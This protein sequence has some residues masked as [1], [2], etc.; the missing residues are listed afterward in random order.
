[1]MNYSMAPKYP[2]QDCSKRH[3]GCHS[4]CASYHQVRDEH[5]RTK[6]LVRA[7]TDRIAF[8]CDEHKRLAAYCTRKRKVFV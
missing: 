4:S 6:S 7:Y 5:E 3:L 8:E 1:M 2:C